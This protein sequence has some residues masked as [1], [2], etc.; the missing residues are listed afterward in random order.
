MGVS[1][2]LLRLRFTRM[3]NTQTNRVTAD[4]A[5]KLT[6]PTPSDV[7]VQLKA[8]VVESTTT[9]RRP[10]AA[11]MR[12]GDTVV[13]RV[14]RGSRTF[15]ARLQLASPLQVPIF[16]AT[17]APALRAMSVEPTVRSVFASFGNVRPSASALA[18]SSGSR[19]RSDSSSIN[20]VMASRTA[21]GSSR[22]ARL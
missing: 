16:L 8:R 14:K 20:L 11:S 13:Y 9:R 21:A 10:R 5:I 2:P 3:Q 17:L 22:A 18:R 12:T 7:P 1:L 4:Y 15:D 19:R 6:R